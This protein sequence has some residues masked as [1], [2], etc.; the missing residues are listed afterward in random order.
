[1]SLGST[2]TLTITSDYAY[3]AEGAKHTAKE[4]RAFPANVDIPANADLVFEVELL[5]IN[6]LRSPQFE[7]KP[8][9][10]E[11]EDILMDSFLP[12]QPKAGAGAG[13]K[14]KSG[15]KKKK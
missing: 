9:T 2:T 4:R 10:K 7:V 12:D 3:A 8:L 5:A 11:E 14:K 13:K 1:M 6:S 15:S